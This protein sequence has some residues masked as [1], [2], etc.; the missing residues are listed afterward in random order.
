[1]R[2]ARLVQLTFL[3]TFLLVLPIFAQAPTDN[4]LTNADIVKMVKAGLP[5]SIIAREIQASRTN[6]GTS[7]TALIELKKQ[8]ASEKILGAVLDSG[9]GTH[10]PEPESRSTSRIVAQGAAP[11]VHHMPS[12]QADMRINPTINGQLSMSHN[13]VKLERAGVPLFSLK[14]KELKNTTSTK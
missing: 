11:E 6:F 13:Q 5:E 4:V 14:W 10:T 1:M 7:P 2:G 8:G 3:L 12:F 9:I